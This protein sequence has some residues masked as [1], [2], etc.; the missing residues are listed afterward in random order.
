[1]IYILTD[2]KEEMA[3]WR[4][5]NQREPQLVT[6]CHGLKMPAKDGKLR[7]NDCVNTENAF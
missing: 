6:I 2:S 4:K 7:T 3:Y 5:L 1:M